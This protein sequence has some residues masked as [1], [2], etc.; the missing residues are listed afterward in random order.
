[1]KSTKFISGVSVLLA[2]SIVAKI[3]GAIFR[4]PLT[5]VLGIDGLGLY[6][7]IYPVFALLI[8]LSSSGM[9]T[10]ISKMVASRIKNNDYIG[11]RQVL[12]VSLAFFGSV[13][14][15]FSVGVFFLSEKI[16]SYQ[17]NELCL[18]GYRA[19]APAIFVVSFLSC[20][21]GYFQ[22][23][24]NMVP[25]ALSF[26]LEQGGKLFFGLLLAYL[27][28]PRGVEY[29]TSGALLG[30]TLSE[31]VAAGVL[32]IIYLKTNKRATN[33]GTKKPVK[34]VIGELIVV[35]FPIVLS[36]ITLPLLAF[37]D[38]FLVVN[39]LQNAFPVDVSTQMWGVCSGVVTSLVNMPIALTLSVSV[40]LVPALVSGGE[41]E[42]SKLLEKGFDL[43]LLITLPIMIAFIIL[44]SEILSTLY[45]GGFISSGISSI[46]TSMLVFCAP[47]VVL[48]S[49]FQT[50]ISSM[51]SLDRGKAVLISLLVAGLIKIILTVILVRVTALNIWGFVIANFVFYAVA[52]AINSVLLKDVFRLGEFVRGIKCNVAACLLLALILLNI[53]LLP[54]YYILKVVLGLILGG[55]GYIFALWVFGFDYKFLTLFKLPRREKS[56]KN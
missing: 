7:L 49:W 5:W 55:G 54:I 14:L 22:G 16:A 9:P 21:R 39:L 4:V 41:E 43:I 23:R 47:L 10:A 6:Q 31:I 56:E 33:E 27:L 42:R 32:W 11:A 17:G 34:A 30:V 3:L 13:S 37:V 29:A 19:I 50:Q 38:S 8:V 12:K 40:S 45:G 15:L 44:S 1:M 35:A 2:S 18:L 51:Q 25:T 52:V 26:I 53:K 28:L 36:S 48:G 20:L 46:A 24:A